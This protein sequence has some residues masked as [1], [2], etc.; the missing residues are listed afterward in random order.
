MPSVWRV[1]MLGGLQ[2]RAHGLTVSRFRTRRVAML[3]AFLAL[4]RDRFHSRDEIT[5]LLWPDADDPEAARRNLR[6]ALHSLR[7]ALEPPSMPA[8]SVL[9]V[10]QSLIRISSEI[11]T[12]DVSEMERLVDMAREAQSGQTRFDYLKQALALYRGDLLPGFD[13]LWVM[14]ERFRMEDLYLSTLSR[15]IDEC[16][17]GDRG[18]EAIHYL[19]LALAKEPRGIV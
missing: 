8:G 18:D 15:I 13:E 3:L 4:H 17:H 14:N 11:L 12:T 10:K 5:E 1:E 9:E 7:K 19:R 6:Q 2:A 16:E